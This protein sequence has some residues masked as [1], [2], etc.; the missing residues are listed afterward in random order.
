MQVYTTSGQT[1]VDNSAHEV[2][3]S[4][5]SSVTGATTY[6]STSSSGFSGITVNGVD[7]T[8]Q[9]TSGDIGAL[10]GLRDTVLPAAQSQLDQLATQLADS[11][12]AVHN[13]GTS[14]PPPSTLTGT[15]AVTSSTQLWQRAQPYRRRRQGNLV[16]YR[17]SI[18]RAVDGRRSGF[19][20]Q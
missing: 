12:N 6:S 18:C 19:G 14:L 9:I 11:L 1:L 8:A 7:I 4:T 20:H 17:I 13:T 3:Y 5:V 15:A 2:S 16:S 10:I